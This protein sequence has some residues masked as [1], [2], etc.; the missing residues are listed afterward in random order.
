MKRQIITYILAA[1]CAAAILSCNKEATNDSIGSD[2]ECTVLLTASI[3]ASTKAVNIDESKVVCTWAVGDT[4]ALVHDNA[5]ISVLKVISVNGNQAQLSGTVKGSY[6][7]EAK[8]KL[9]YGGTFYDYTNQTGTEASAVSKAYLQ[10]DTKVESVSTDRKT[11]KL[12][13]TTMEHQQSY[14]GLKFYK[15]SSLVKVDS[16]VIKKGGDVIVKTI[17]LVGEP[18]YYGDEKFV[19]KSQ[20]AGGQ[21]I[22]YFAL[23]D[24][25]IAVGH[26]YDLEISEHGEPN[27]YYG[28]V[29]APARSN[30]FEFSE[31]VLDRQ[32]IWLSPVITAPTVYAY[33]EYDGL[34]HNLVTPAVVQPGATVYYCVKPDLTQ[35]V[36]PD[37][38]TWTTTIP[39]KTEVGGYDVWYKVDGGSNY[40]DILATKVGNAYIRDDII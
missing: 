19:V 31:V 23:R 40:E 34:P 24:T 12:E 26:E 13:S 33:I 5:R 2:T 7:V 27:K 3:D 11:L 17:P 39:S 1:F 21:E 16:V 35:P 10:A 8:M 37:N 38:W 30:Y 32:G 9:Y 18:T 15:V 22:F 36:N 29:K 14:I 6:A 20:L 28:K 4:V 25:S